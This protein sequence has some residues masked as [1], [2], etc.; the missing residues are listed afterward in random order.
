MAGERTFSVKSGPEWW[1]ES[2][3]SWITAETGENCLTLRRKDNTA[4]LQ[5]LSGEVILSNGADSAVITVNHD[6]AIAAPDVTRNGVLLSADENDP[7]PIPAGTFRLGIEDNKANHVFLQFSRKNGN[8]Y[9]DR[10]WYRTSNTKISVEKSVS[11]GEIYRITASGHFSGEQGSY[12]RYET[13]GDAPA[14]VFYIRLTDEGQYLNIEGRS[15][16][17]IEE[18]ADSTTRLRIYCS[19]PNFTWTAD[20]SWLGLTVV[21]R[22]A[23]SYVLVDAGPTEANHTGAEREGAITLT[24]P[25]KNL[26]AVIRVRQADAELLEI[27]ANLYTLLLAFNS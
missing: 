24:D 17:L 2:H 16:Y 23:E 26:Q 19:D 22:S 27:C 3:P 14:N 25:G 5:E 13:P 21:S 1:V 18:E 6:D 10:F 15:E 12:G 8:T 20:R 11:V 7:T 4:W 9:Q